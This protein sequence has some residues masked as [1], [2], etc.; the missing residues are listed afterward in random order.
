[1]KVCF[2]L[3]KHRWCRFNFSDARILNETSNTGVVILYGIN[4]LNKHMEIWHRSLTMGSEK[5][6]CFH[7]S[8]RS[9]ALPHLHPHKHTFSYFYNIQICSSRTGWLF[10]C[11]YCPLFSPKQ[12]EKREWMSQLTVRVLLLGEFSQ[13]EWVSG[14]NIPH[15]LKTTWPEDEATSAGGRLK[16]LERIRNKN[17]THTQTRFDRIS[18]LCHPKNL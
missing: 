5:T 16:V 14:K 3:F 17:K 12:S 4:S 13:L 2:Y 7:F 9:A 1:M 10:Q 6:M 15:C 8:H 18:P 11:H